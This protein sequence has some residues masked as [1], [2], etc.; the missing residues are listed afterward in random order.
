MKFEEFALRLPF[1]LKSPYSPRFPGVGGGRRGLLGGWVDVVR[2]FGLPDVG[3]RWIL[4]SDPVVFWGCG[5]YAAIWRFKCR[6]H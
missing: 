6:G 3:C 2:G 4:S 5:L 1:F